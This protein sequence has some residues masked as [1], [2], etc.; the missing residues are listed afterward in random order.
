MSNVGKS[1]TIGFAL[2]NHTFRKV[3][4]MVLDGQS[5]RFGKCL[6]VSWLLEDDFLANLGKDFGC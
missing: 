1:E 2:L 5:I 6:M 3:K 4:G